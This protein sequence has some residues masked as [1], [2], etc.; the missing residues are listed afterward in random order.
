ML[1]NAGMIESWNAADVDT[2]FR[3]IGHG[4]NIK[5]GVKGADIERR[6]SQIR[7][8]R[9]VELK[10]FQSREHACGFISGVDAEMGHRSMSGDA[11]EGQ[12]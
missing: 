6:R 1:L 8:W 4:I 11:L 2:N 7:M 12:A 9:Y 3:T 10:S 5:T